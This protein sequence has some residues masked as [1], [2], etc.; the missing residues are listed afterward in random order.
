MLACNSDAQAVNP[1]KAFLE[2]L[3]FAPIYSNL[4]KKNKMTLQVIAV[5]SA[6]VSQR[7]SRR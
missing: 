3:T 1:D 5:L 4:A 7:P 2:A 6:I